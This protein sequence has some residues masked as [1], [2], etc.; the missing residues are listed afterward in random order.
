MFKYSIIFLSL[1]LLASCTQIP[2]TDTKSPPPQASV[3]PTSK[4]LYV[5]V[6]EDDEWTAGHIE[7]AMHVKLGEIEAGKFDQIPK[8]TPVSLYCRSGR[9]SG[10]AYRILKNAGYTHIT[11]VWAMEQLQGVTI[12]R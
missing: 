5:D 8:D 12:V 9:R 6:R 1:L 3:T 7:W 10:I 2:K 11:D 4:T